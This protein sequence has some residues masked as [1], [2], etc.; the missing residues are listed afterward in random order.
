MSF[1]VVDTSKYHRKRN[2]G[3][4]RLRKQQT[5]LHLPTFPF[6]DR[7]DKTLKNMRNRGNRYKHCLSSIS[8]IKKPDA[9]L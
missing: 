6:D 1:E 3:S 8:M 7:K 9:L 5:Q 2:K 4:G